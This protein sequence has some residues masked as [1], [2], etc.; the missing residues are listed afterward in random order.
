MLNPAAAANLDPFFAVH[1]EDITVNGDT[2]K[3]LADVGY[4]LDPRNPERRQKNV[5]RGF[6]IRTSDKG[7]IAKGNIVVYA[8]AQYQVLTTPEDD[9]MGL[10]S[11][12]V[13]RGRAA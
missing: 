2:I 6:T 8:G 7:S 9:G 3:A 4:S 12:Q 10:T 13:S 5:D 11:F 1:G